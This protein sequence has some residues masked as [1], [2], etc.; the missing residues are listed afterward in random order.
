MAEISSFESRTGRLTCDAGKA[1]DFLSDLRN[2]RQFIPAGTISNIV[3]DHDSCSFRVDM[4]GMVSIN[5]LEKVRPEKIVYSGTIPQVKDL[6]MSVDI[7]ENT[8]G[9]SDVK[10]MVRAEIN[11]FLKMM[12]EEPIRKVLEKVIDE[13]EKLR[14]WES[15]T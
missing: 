12:A 15:V 11:P 13:M 4:L 1:F 7:R 9:I 2:F 8:P 14:D 5:I 6:S 3:L 10:L